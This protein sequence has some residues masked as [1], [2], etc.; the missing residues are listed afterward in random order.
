MLKVL[1]FFSIVFGLCRFTLESSSKSGFSLWI[2]A[3]PTS[4]NSTR[5]IISAGFSPKDFGASPFPSNKPQGI[6]NAVLTAAE[7]PSALLSTTNQREC[8]T[9]GKN[10][11]TCDRHAEHARI[12]HLACIAS[13]NIM[14]QPW[15]M[16]LKFDSNRVQNCWNLF[17]YSH[18]LSLVTACHCLFEAQGLYVFRSPDCSAGPVVLTQ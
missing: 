5:L 16:Q 1:S 8:C 6:I 18:S 9:F 12:L 10:T 7:Q 17:L 11:F 4:S 15:L 13:A 2:Y 14:S 3:V